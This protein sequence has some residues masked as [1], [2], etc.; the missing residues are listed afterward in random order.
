MKARIC[1]GLGVPKCCYDR[2][3]VVARERGGKKSYPCPGH[4]GRSVKE[5]GTRVTEVDL[6]ERVSRITIDG[7]G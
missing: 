5:L 4:V 7:S 3:R 6:R 2:E 1:S